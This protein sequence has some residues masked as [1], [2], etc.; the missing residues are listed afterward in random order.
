MS[1]Q[2][3]HLD[4]ER[5]RTFVR[6]MARHDRRRRTPCSAD[7]VMNAVIGF[8]NAF[9]NAAHV[10][11]TLE[12]ADLLELVALYR[13]LRGWAN[14]EPIAPPGLFVHLDHTRLTEASQ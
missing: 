4:P 11:L 3:A 12:R 10:R 6:A 7:D 5:L 2:Q 9:A 8:A 1:Q 14:V 13:G